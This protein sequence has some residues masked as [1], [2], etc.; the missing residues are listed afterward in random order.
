MRPEQR[1]FDNHRPD[2]P[3]FPYY[4]FLETVMG[5]N[6][7]CPMCPVSNTKEFMNGRKFTYMEPTLYRQVIDEL[8]AAG[9]K[10]EIWLNQLGEPTLHRNLVE[11]VRYASTRGHNVCMTSNGT[12]LTPELSDGLLQAG[13]RQLHFSIDGADQ[14][15]YEK[16][17]VGGHYEDTVRKVSDF[18]DRNKS[19]GSPV[20]VR[21]DCIETSLTASQKTDFL[22]FW[23][24]KAE[25]SFIPL[26]DWSGQMELPAEFGPP[27]PLPPEPA[28]RYPCD[29]LWTIL[30]VAA[31][32][33]GMFCCHDYRLQSNMPRV[34][35]VGL[36]GLWKAQGMERARHTAGEYIKAPCAD[37]YEWRRRPAPAPTKFGALHSQVVIPLV[38]IGSR[39]RKAVGI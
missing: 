19:A 16:I 11:F 25:V 20:K 37:C 6:L 8:T 2:V 32:G 38:Q 30:T 5:C 18:C 4:I 12:R 1:A 24:P 26:S 27:L 31:D 14:A 13:L 22:A 21:I 35:D 28:E 10:H 15:T 17:R 9:G 39:V 34:Q 29:L 33:R 7:R 36:T 3:D 23:S